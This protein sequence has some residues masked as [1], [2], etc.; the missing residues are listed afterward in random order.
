MSRAR[1]VTIR[2]SRPTLSCRHPGLPPQCASA[3][4]LDRGDG[5]VSRLR[6]YSY[7]W[8]CSVCTTQT[9]FF[10]GD[11]HKQFLAS[12]WKQ[13]SSWTAHRYVSNLFLQKNLTSSSIFSLDYK[14]KKARK[15]EN[16]GWGN[17]NIETKDRVLELT[18]EVTC[19]KCGT[20]PDTKE[21]F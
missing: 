4:S 11:T 12:T 18:W 21:F 6:A 9:F 10:V 14:Q 7:I 19:S 16:E 2:L 13:E 1:Q 15:T 5:E 17:N 20:N 8:F 3:A